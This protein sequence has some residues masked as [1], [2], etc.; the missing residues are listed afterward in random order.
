MTI[1]TIAVCGAG[2]MGRGIA[3]VCATAGFFTIVYEPNE[4][5]LQSAQESVGASL[6]KLEEK[7]KLT[8]GKASG[9]MQRLHFTSDIEDCRAELI[10]E[11]I[12]EVQEVKSSLFSRLAEINNRSTIFASNTSSLSITDLAAATANPRQFAGLHFFN[13]APLM[14]LVE[15]VRGEQTSE[16][17]ITELQQLVGRLAK[18]GVLCTDAP[19]FIVNRVARPFYIEAL[20]QAEAGVP[21]EKI[22]RLMEARGFKMGPFR[23][24]D[25]IGNDVNYAVSCSVHEQLGKPERLKPSYLQQEK[26]ALNEL[27]KKTG[28]GYYTYGL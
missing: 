17:V 12:V 15:I 5:V 9:I 13:P 20:R 4:A 24:M 6:Q 3:Q 8:T 21:L 11:A 22:D 10:I 1:K 27:G 18:T 7:G 2:T 25:L 14:R 16:E 26:V 23:L 28:K 19:G